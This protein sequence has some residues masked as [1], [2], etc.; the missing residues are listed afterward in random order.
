MHELSICEGIIAVATDALRGLPAPPPSVTRI[1]VQIGRL[2]G[3]VADSLRYHFELL[4]AGTAL[5]GARLVVEEVPIRG[6][7]ADCAAEFEIPTLFF[8]CPLCGSGFVDLR[9][10]HELRVVSLDTAEEVPCAS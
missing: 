6:R 2:T 9:S 5:D 4:S 1:T 8:S 10:G 3:I 7:C